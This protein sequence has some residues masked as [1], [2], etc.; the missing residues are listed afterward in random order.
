M[1]LI[2]GSPLQIT[3][4]SMPGD[5]EMIKAFREDCLNEEGADVIILIALSTTLSVANVILTLN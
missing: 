1:N 3:E 2:S 4:L 5:E